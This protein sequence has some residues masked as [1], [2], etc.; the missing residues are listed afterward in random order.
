MQYQKVMCLFVLL[1]F[2]DSL[3]LYL[4]QSSPRQRQ[5]RLPIQLTRIRPR[6]IKLILRHIRH[7]R[8]ILIRQHQEQHQQQREERRQHQN[9][10][11]LHNK[12]VKTTD[13]AMI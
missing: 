11:S 13:T 3:Q 2:L 8:H 9:S 5:L 6:H 7:I 12:R 1:V 10:I 4:L